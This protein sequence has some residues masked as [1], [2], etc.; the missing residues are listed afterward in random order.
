MKLFK[1]KSGNITL[2]AI[3]VS[4]VLIGFGIT[5]SSVLTTSIISTGNVIKSNEAYYEAEA[6]AENGYYIFS[7]HSAGFEYN[8]DGDSTCE[9][10]SGEDKWCLRSRLNN[11]PNTEPEEGEVFDVLQDNGVISV[12]LYNDT[13]ISPF[14]SVSLSN[15]D[16][17]S[18]ALSIKIYPTQDTGASFLNTVGVGDIRVTRINRD[19]YDYDE[20]TKVEVGNG[21]VGRQLVSNQKMGTTCADANYS[22]TGNDLIWDT[23]EFLYRDVDMSKDVSRGDIRMVNIG[24]LGAGTTVLLGDPDIT[25]DLHRFENDGTGIVNLACDASD[26]TALYVTDVAQIIVSGRDDNGN[27]S[28]VRLISKNQLEGRTAESYLFLSTSK[29]VGEY[30]LAA[31]VH[32]L[33]E[34]CSIEDFLEEDNI[35]C[36]NTGK[37]NEPQLEIYSF[38]EQLSYRI[39]TN[40]SDFKV[41][42]DLAC[43]LCDVI[44]IASPGAGSTSFAYIQRSD[45]DI[46]GIN[47]PS[48]VYVL[49]LQEYGDITNRNVGN[50]TIPVEGITPSKLAIEIQEKINNAG[51]LKNNYSVSFNDS[52]FHIFST[53]ETTLTNPET[54]LVSKVNYEGF[55]QSIQTTLT[56]STLVPIFGWYSVF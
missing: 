3:I 22:I 45:G 18:Y 34:E 27:Q 50:I 1:K 54:T 43:T 30:S 36:G 26:F 23:G 17:D 47:A 56:D 44:D 52:K 14:G 46:S 20:R 8:Y 28:L 25:I 11:I 12:G 2:M 51:I 37:M 53:G 40:F 41:V 49:V 42:E 35:D 9:I 32:Y 39:E 4:S 38:S 33:E 6:G 55:Q 10:E 5:L 31:N 24:S 48:G 15:V 29:G 7:G 13:S 19:T 21:D 16:L